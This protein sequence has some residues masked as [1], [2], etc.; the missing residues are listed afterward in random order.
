MTFETLALT[1]W[2][3]WDKIASE[4]ALLLNLNV[5]LNFEESSADIQSRR[6]QQS[7]DILKYPTTGRESTDENNVMNNSVNIDQVSLQKP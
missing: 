5:N 3:G 4:T 1:K 6:S 7:S 2:P